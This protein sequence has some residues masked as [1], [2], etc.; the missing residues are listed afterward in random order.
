[1]VLVTFIVTEVVV[2]AS[3][4]SDELLSARGALCCYFCHYYFAVLGCFFEGVFLG[5]VCFCLQGLFF[6]SFLSL[7]LF[8]FRGFG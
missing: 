7:S 5:F 2:L 3:E 1:M 4:V 8:D 6:S